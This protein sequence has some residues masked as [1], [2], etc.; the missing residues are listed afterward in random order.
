MTCGFA[1]HPNDHQTLCVGYT[2]G[3]V[4]FTRNG[5]ESWR[6]LSVAEGKLY[7]MRLIATT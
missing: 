7:G 3:A 6:Q 4:Y 5:G 1:V 2:D